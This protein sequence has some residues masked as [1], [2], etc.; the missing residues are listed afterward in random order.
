MNLAFHIS[1]NIVSGPLIRCRIRMEEGWSRVCP[2]EPGAGQGWSPL[3]RAHTPI[4]PCLPPLT[5]RSPNM[6][7][8]P[9]STDSRIHPP[10]SHQTHRGYRLSGTLLRTE[11]KK[12]V[13]ARSD[14]CPL[15]PRPKCFL[16]WT[17]G[18]VAFER[19]DRKM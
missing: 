15:K 16:C 19:G 9:R 5:S 12:N 8:P 13:Q 6:P 14:F 4:G 1:S 17:D 10:P 3:T 18:A 11:D 2:S 7:I